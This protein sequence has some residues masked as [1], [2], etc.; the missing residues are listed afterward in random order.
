MLDVGQDIHSLTEFKTRTAE[1][2]AR[3]RKSGRASLLTVNGRAEVAVMSA[4]TFQRV[5]EAFETLD[6]MRGIKAG[7]DDAKAGR[8]RPAEEFFAEVRGRKGRARRRA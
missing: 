8:T 6:A 2:L 3:L 5:L 7:L 4:A 1:F